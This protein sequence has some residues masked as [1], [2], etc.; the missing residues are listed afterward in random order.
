MAVQPFGKLPQG[1]LTGEIY[2]QHAKGDVK[3]KDDFVMLN[4]EQ[5]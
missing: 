2:L 4:E 1:G 5:S 3:S